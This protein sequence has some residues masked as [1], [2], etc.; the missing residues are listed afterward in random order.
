MV[1]RCLVALILLLLAPG[2]DAPVDDDSAGATADDDD[3]DD[4][5]AAAPPYAAT[6]EIVGDLPAGV[7]GMAVADDGVLWYGDTFGN[8]SAA[9][10]VYTVAPPYNGEHVVVPLD[11]EQPAGMRFIDGD[12]YVC[13]LN[14]SRVVRLDSG[15]EIEQSWDVSYP[16]NVRAMPDGD[17][18]VIT[19]DQGLFRL[20][21]DGTT[22]LLFGGLALPFDLEP[23]T[24]DSVWISE[25]GEGTYG[26]GRVARWALDGTQVEEIVG[27]W[28]NPEGMALDDR[29]TLWIAETDSGEIRR[30]DADGTLSVA[31]DEYTVP[32]LITPIP[33]GDLLVNLRS[34][35]G[36]HLARIHLE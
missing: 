7:H 6:I 2:C 3:D 19:Y 26:E 17:V 8:A 27:E 1:K 12:P 36:N 5:T 9:Q 21:D 31:F 35:L 23:A 33:D 25:Q 10:E 14:G 29:G 28:P 18:L 22:E 11:L 15:L 34:A 4:D 32:I 24:A 13:D 30:R 16:W 20:N